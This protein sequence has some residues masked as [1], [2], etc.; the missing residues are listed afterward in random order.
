MRKI[1][2]ESV[3]VN[4]FFPIHHT[5]A[6]A[7]ASS[8]LLLRSTT[9]PVSTVCAPLC[10]VTSVK[11]NKKIYFMIFFLRE[12]SDRGAW[13]PSHLKKIKRK[14]CRYKAGYPSRLAWAAG[15]GK[16]QALCIAEQEPRT[17]ILRQMLR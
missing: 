13:R 10:R 4:D 17:G 12:M 8:R 14:V 2:S 11:H 15:N 5:D 9:L 1:P 6:P 3:W 16:R 7:T